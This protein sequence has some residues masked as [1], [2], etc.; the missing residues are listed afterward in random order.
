MWFLCARCKEI[1][2]KKIKEKREKSSQCNLLKEDKKREKSNVKGNVNV[3]NTEA[4]LQG[5]VLNIENP[6]QGNVL[7]T[8]NPSAR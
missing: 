3:L 2:K 8:E 7:S 5:N 1:R 4:S 6:L